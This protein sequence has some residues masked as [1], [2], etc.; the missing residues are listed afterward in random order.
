MCKRFL[1]YEFRQPETLLLRRE[2]FFPPPTQQAQ[3]LVKPDLGINF[4][5]FLFALTIT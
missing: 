5:Y 1:W 4:I 2:W 3:P